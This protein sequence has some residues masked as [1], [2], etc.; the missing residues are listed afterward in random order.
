MAAG[1]LSRV[2]GL[3]RL[4][5]PRLIG[6]EGIGLYQMAYPIYAFSLAL[7]TGGFPVAVSKLVAER[8]AVGDHGGAQWVLRLSVLLLAFLGIIGAALLVVLA[9][10]FARR[11][12]H[13]PR[14]ELPLLAIAPAVFL[15]S[16]LS[17][18]RGYFQ[19]LQDMVPTALSQLLEQLVRV[20][21]IVGL[22]LLLRP[23]GV[24]VQ[25]AGAAFGAV[26]GALAA[27]L[28]LLVLYLRLPKDPQTP[29][30]EGRSA[31]F[32]LGRLVAL[33]I[34]MALSGL[35]AP[36]MQLLDLAI[37]PARL[38]ASGLSTGRRALVYGHLAGY[39]T[40]IANLPPIFT[41]AIV[42]AVIP[43][44]ADTLARGE[45]SAAVLQARTAIRTSA[46]LLLP[47]ALGVMLL[48]HPLM[49][50]LY[51]TEAPAAALQALSGSVA[52]LGLGQTVAGVLQGAGD[53]VSPVRNML[54]ALLTKVILTW[55][56]LPPLGIRGAALASSLGYLVFF[57][58][59]L[60]D[61][62]R[63]LP[64]AV[65]LRDYLL[66]IPAMLSMTAV[67]VSA[68]R[69]LLSQGKAGILALLLLSLAAYAGGAL[70]SGVVPKERLLL[71]PFGSLLVRMLRVL[72]LVQ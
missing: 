63:R 49:R 10:W 1:I 36:L 60:F 9:P 13:D 67:I 43:A 28:L 8:E 20:A 16:V 11:L 37:V 22:V 53:A 40:P 56:L 6:A 30:T 69:P 27:L 65:R 59:N 64:E 12:A 61:L 66:P 57:A 71:L 25:A 44:V 58:G 21:T 47:A 23:Y 48:A 72:R 45:R 14:A 50:L 38:L 3:Y 26:T 18:F 41:L 55:F 39:A 19:G 15:V 52:F 2:L 70:A 29:R 33:A 68:H 54:Y 35:L 32:W 7:A 42:A 17:A 24:T 51:D 31:L 62:W 46:I 34:P 4:F 5:L